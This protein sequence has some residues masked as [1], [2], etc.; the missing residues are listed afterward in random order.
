[1]Q[2]P[3]RGRARARALAP[4]LLLIA[5]GASPFAGPALAQAPL[6]PE[7]QLAHDIYRQLIEINTTASVGSTTEAAKA[8]AD[9]LLAAGFP[10]ADVQ[11]L[12]PPTNARRGNLV[13][14]MR[15][16]S[17][18]LKPIL[19][20]AHLDVVEARKEDWSADL[21]PFR[22]TEK[23]GFYYGRGTSDDKAMAAIWIANLIRL[24][25]DGFRP[26]RDI[27]VALTADEEGGDWNGVK[28]L[29]AEHPD[30]VAADFGLNEGGGGELR[31]GRHVAN[32]VG[33]AEKV[34]IDFTLEATNP[35]GHS[36][37]PRKENAIYHVARA[38]SRL[39]DF[40]FPAQ[41]NETTRAYLQRMGTIEASDT[42]RD[43]KSA[44][45]G[46]QAAIARLSD[47]P[48][49]NA[50]LRTTCVATMLSAGHA[51]NALPQRATANV[52]CRM[53]PGT[54]EADVK[55]TLQRVLDDTTVTVTA[56]APAKPSPPSPLR[57]DVLAPI[58]QITTAM[59]P[60]TAVVPTMGTGA[61]DGLYFRQRGIPIYGVSGL[62][63]E[64][65][66]GR[67]HGRDERMGIT[68][69]YDGQEFLYRLVKAYTDPRTCC[70]KQPLVP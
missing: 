39:A 48:V 40:S 32:M 58:E 22:F 54:N 6:P 31:E 68:S 47:N 64:M 65:G 69:F 53:L 35:G 61:T 70:R 51:T 12:V 46:D 57:P 19:L 25:R 24:R 67:A 7:R 16:S 20:L 42:G 2:P 49:Y 21:D 13:A 60:G 10:A 8:M 23:D 26:A 4:A 50:I 17:A 34:Y 3:I 29:L 44:A 37:V 28:W 14:R 30:L 1:M 45:A 5:L 52:N 56:V 33:T 38:L 43:M 18:A 36:S 27:V 62:F 11:L 15:G 66:E 59:W 9:R 55:A 63:T 41:L